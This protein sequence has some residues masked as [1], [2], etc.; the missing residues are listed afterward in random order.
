VA[1]LPILWAGFNNFRNY[2]IKEGAFAAWSHPD[3]LQLRHGLLTRTSQMVPRTR[4]QAISLT[5][6]Y[7]WRQADWWRL[8]MNIAGYGLSDDEIRTVLLPVG[9][10]RA[11]SLALRAVL[12]ELPPVDDWPALLTALYGQGDDGFV[13]TPRR[14]RY[15]APLSWR[16]LG[17]AVEAPWLLIRSGRWTRQVVIVPMGRTQ[18][19]ELWQGPWQRRLQVA[20][21]T[22]NSTAG[23]VGP[24]IRQ[25]DFAVAL[26]LIDLATRGLLGWRDRP[27]PA[28]PDELAAA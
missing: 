6:R 10:R 22:V 19:F 26:R 21:L 24:L 13:T 28:T 12:P 23:P 16:R 17:F 5:Q 15:F 4:I 9:D 3:G 11:V 1:W 18:G 20:N 8:E 2:V 14:A 27:V 25:L 7:W